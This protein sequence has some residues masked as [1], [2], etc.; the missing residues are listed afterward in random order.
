MSE[1]YKSVLQKLLPLGRIWTRSSK[2][3]LSKLLEGIG[4]EFER[5]EKR[6]YDLIREFDPRT[7]VESVEDWEE[8]LGLP[9]E[10]DQVQDSSLERRYKLIN[11]ALSFRGGQTPQ[12]FVDYINALGFNA[13]VYEYREFRAGISAVGDPLSNGIDWV[14][15][16]QLTLPATISYEF[17]VDVSTVGEALRVFKNDSVECSI[18]H[19]KPA[20]TFVIFAFET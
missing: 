3:T 17:S 11:R 16:W 12:Y 4:T 5:V 13:S 14:N 15:T 7:S 6:G 19:I 9:D 1:K 20:Q 2:S 8:F 18:G 10:C